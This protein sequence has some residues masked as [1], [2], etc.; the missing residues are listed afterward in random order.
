MRF[1]VLFFICAC[2]ASVA[3]AQ[4]IVNIPPTGHVSTIQSA[5]VS[6]S[7]N[8][9]I[10][11]PAGVWR[12][13][14]C[15]VSVTIS[16]GF[17][18]YVYGSPTGRTVIDCMGRGRFL[19]VVASGDVRLFNLTIINGRAT[20]M[21][22][23]G[24]ALYLTTSATVQLF[25]VE[26]R[27]CTAA[28]GGAIAVGESV[29]LRVENSTFV[30][31]VASLNGG[32]VAATGGP[33]TVELI[34][35]S[36]T[37]C[38][39]G[40]LGGALACT[41]QQSL[42][43][44]NPSIY[45]RRSRISS[46][47]AGVAGGA[48]VANTTYAALFFHNSTIDNCTAP[49]GGALHLIFCGYA[50]LAG[51]N[52]TNNKASGRGGAIFAGIR[53]PGAGYATFADLFDTRMTRNSADLGGALFFTNI[54]G[55]DMHNVVLS[56]NT[57]RLGGAVYATENWLNFFDSTFLANVA[58]VNG[59]AVFLTSVSD[60]G[61]FRNVTLTG[62]QAV[63]GSAIYALN[64]VGV[65]ANSVI[66]GNT[67]F[68]TGAVFL[69]SSSAWMDADF[70]RLCGNV[71]RSCRPDLFCPLSVSFGSSVGF[72]NT[73][74]GAGVCSHSAAGCNTTYNPATC[75]AAAGGCL[76]GWGGAACNRRT[77]CSLPVAATTNC[78]E[79]CTACQTSYGLSPLGVCIPCADYGLFFVA[80]NVRMPRFLLLQFKR[81][82]ESDDKSCVCTFAAYS[83]SSSSS[84]SCC[85]CIFCC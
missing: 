74:A 60:T 12:G 34:S 25:S 31:C 33:S 3:S 55:G 36:I 44:Q 42:P 85:S 58:S 52:V 79:P 6:A 59:G 22:G 69:A 41:G 23:L 37:N 61:S 49:D 11:I 77:N 17:P 18:L 47:R 14:G 73:C 68:G 65:L 35:V 4:V 20:N 28:I 10:F 15:N 30:S 71:A 78:F 19:S 56:Y 64:N 48:A 16:A 82:R 67:A 29:D 43:D 8:S 5:L 66:T 13:N 9:R 24:G 7:A 27:D 50:L 62:N 81:N 80:T 1:L 2:C 70:T 40:N 45:V 51:C 57:A 21:A 53:L 32:A 83:S 46:C 26:F 72:P 76:P 38:S 63:N 75:L 54:S 39:A 84:S